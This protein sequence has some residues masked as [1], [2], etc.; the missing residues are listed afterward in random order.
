M[1]NKL[2]PAEFYRSLLQS[3]GCTVH[4]ETGFVHIDDGSAAKPA[5]TINK[6]QLVL[7]TPEVLRRGLT[8]T[9]IG[10]APAGE[11]AF[12]RESVVMKKFRELVTTRI[13][14]VT[15]Q[16]LEQLMN[17][18]A[19][20][21]KHPLLTPQQSEFLSVVPEVNE[22]TTLEL[23][24]LL[25]RIDNKGENRLI[26]IYIKPNGKIGDEVVKRLAAV[27]FPIME[28][29]QQEGH[30]IFGVQMRKGNKKAILDLLEFIFPGCEKVG[31]WNA[32]S[33]DLAA[34]AFHAMLL[35]F[36]GLIN[37]LNEIVELFDNLLTS[38]IPLYSEVDWQAGM[39]DIAKLRA[40][41]PTLPGND[42]DIVR[43]SATGNTPT[44]EPTAPTVI[45][46]TSAAP[47]V[48][49]TTT[50]T[51]VQTPKVQAN[52]LMSLAKPLTEAKGYN[53]KPAASVGFTV[54]EQPQQP[55]YAAPTAYAQPAQPMMSWAEKQAQLQ[56][57]Q[58]AY[59]QPAYPQAGYAVGGTPY[60]QQPAY[61][62]PAYGQQQVAY[63]PPVP[64]TYHQPRPVPAHLAH[65][66]VQFAPDGTP[67]D[68]AGQVIPPEIMVQLGYNLEQ[69]PVAPAYGQP[70]YA[71]PAYG[72]QAY[73]PVPP[74][75]QLPPGRAQAA[76]R[77]EA[78][79]QQQAY[80]AYQQP[81]YYR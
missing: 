18:A 28:A 54:T 5:L 43:D 24:S 60:P 72:Q 46:G 26:Q 58:L 17:I 56:Q 32:G 67:F 47:T 29:R 50:V 35:A 8:P 66:Q 62:Q 4:P 53:A 16:L 52:G 9:Q 77:L 21:S 1:E 41:I 79:R 71:Q 61:A 48:A 81:P 75:Q 80:G 15:M 68:Q 59:A 45:P 22:K 69:V 7:P 73:G 19:D 34:P 36:A 49:P 31:A 14:Y 23:S 76:A 70:A 30:K 55:A 40:A 57:Q 38:P 27:S 3:C 12:R 6:H 20:H 51:T 10:F 44:T 78:K 13:T 65:V 2:T 33:H 39:D 64:Q 42:G 63:A 11:S 37:R 25:D 74:S